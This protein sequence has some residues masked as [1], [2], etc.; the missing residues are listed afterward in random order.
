VL[1]LARLL[2]FAAWMSP[3]AALPFAGLPAGRIVAACIAA[4]LSGALLS[5]LPSGAFRIARGAI[6]LLQPLSLLWIGYVT[7][8]G[9]GPTADAALGAMAHTNIDEATTALKLLA[10]TKSLSI[11]ILQSLLLAASFA[12]GNGSR[13]RLSGAIA[14][15]GLTALMLIVWIQQLSSNVPSIVPGRTD[16]QNF[17]YGSMAELA[18]AL[19]SDRSVLRP[20]PGPAVSHRI[21]SEPAVPS[22]IDAIFV[23]GESFRFDRPA[24]LNYGGDGWLALRRRIRDGLGVFLPK[25][26]ASADSTAISVPML[27]SGTSP[28]ASS[29]AATAPSGLARLAAA[30]YETAWISN[31]AGNNLFGDEHR[32]LFWM[33]EGSSPQYDEALL[34]RASA[35]L[36]TDAGSNK[37]VLLHF[38]DSHAAYVDRYPPLQE[39]EQL[40]REHL[41]AL[42]YERAND[43]TLRVLASVAAIIDG[44]ST[45]AFVVY[46]SDHGE[47]LLVDH[48]GIHFHIG[49][50]T[51]AKAAYVPSFVFW[52]DAYLRAFHPKDRLRPV[53]AAAA[54]AHADVYRIWMNFAGLDAAIAATP[55][56]QIL[57]KANLTDP[58]GAVSCAAL[59]P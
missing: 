14:A 37:A 41:E 50:R 13:V 30:G 51:T 10:N 18:A 56:P 23:L 49:A 25:V 42:R 12:C 27:L 19:A 58:V 52:N 9:M 15:A 33:V 40:D 1:D 21:P 36:E 38:L 6:L 48:N 53:L 46:V 31:Q 7:L 8:N 57:G 2:L 28:L 20:N 17:P 32:D 5:S 47:N 39:P 22:S 55:D 43:H 54:L 4:A 16:L 35:F 44:L 34:P 59:F 29:D 45:P 3:M 26:C 11:G 24:G